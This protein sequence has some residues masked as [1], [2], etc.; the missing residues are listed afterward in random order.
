MSSSHLQ[1][2]TVY[3]STALH[4]NL[5]GAETIQHCMSSADDKYLP[6]TNFKGPLS[7]KMLAML[8]HQILVM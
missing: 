8:V 6:K 5:F 7:L 4:R 2:Y 3:C 1:C